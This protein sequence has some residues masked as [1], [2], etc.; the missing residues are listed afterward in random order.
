MGT[1]LMTDDVCGLGGRNEIT[2]G[3]QSVA[4]FY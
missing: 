4:S 3:L 1:G 2:E